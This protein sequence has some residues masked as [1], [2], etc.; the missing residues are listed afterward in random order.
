MHFTLRNFNPR[1]SF[2]LTF[3]IA[4]ICL[5]PIL[6]SGLYSDDL[7]GF[8]ARHGSAY[9]THK[10]VAELSSTSIVAWIHY[11]RFSPLALT[12]LEAVFRVFPS[13]GCY[14]IY[15]FIANVLALISFVALLWVIGYRALIPLFL[16]FYSAGVQFRIQYHDGYTSFA[17][18][19]QLLAF[20]MF[21]SATTYVLYQRN[22][23]WF[24]LAISLILFASALLTSELAVAEIVLL[25]FCGYIGIRNWRKTLLSLLP[26]I[27]VQLVYFGIVI[28]VRM[29]V[30]RVY[31]GIAANLE[32]V[33]MF[34]TFKIQMFS[35]LPFSNLY[36]QVAIPGILI[37]QL[38]NLFNAMAVSAILLSFLVWIWRNPRERLANNGNHLLVAI[39]AV[40]LATIP[41]IILS[42][43]VKYQQELRFGL[44]YLPVYLQN[45]G[46]ALLLAL[47]C[48]LCLQHAMRFIR[49]FGAIMTI[50]AL[51]GVISAFLFNQALI[52]VKDYTL[53]LPAQ[54]L[55]ENIEQGF[56]N[57]CEQ[58]SRIVLQNSFYYGGIGGYDSIIRTVS[59]K[60]FYLYNGSEWIPGKEDSL[61][62]NCYSLSCTA[63]DTIFTRLSKVNCKSGEIGQLLKEKVQITGLQVVDVEKPIL[64]WRD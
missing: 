44:G 31:S 55:Y 46:L 16:L 5:L 10:S 39:F 45:F 24:C 20:C 56:L 63:G 7:E 4:I 2:I 21:A 33:A 12:Q 25:F 62:V 50:T 6:K 23:K 49:G 60:V 53:S 9:F 36:K 3:S 51:V 11:G 52:K 15:V 40:S 58:H 57:D 35:A 1:L 38:H 54:A 18:M 59:G 41:A 14:K 34:N 28:Y 13:V 43:A 27:L 22:R 29:Q 30:P 47:I 8:Q 17:G 37:R 26:F 32:P 61:R 48:M 42:S 19:Y 64:Q